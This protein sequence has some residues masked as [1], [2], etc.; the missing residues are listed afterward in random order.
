M[1]TEPATYHVRWI[2]ERI[3]ADGQPAED[4]TT[5]AYIADFSIAMGTELGAGPSILAIDL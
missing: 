3:A 2:T 5:T 4:G 1:S